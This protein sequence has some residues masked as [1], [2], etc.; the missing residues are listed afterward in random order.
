MIQFKARPWRVDQSSQ[1]FASWTLDDKAFF[2][3]ASRVIALICSTSFYDWSRKLALLS[4]PIRCK[5]QT[6][7]DLVVRVFPP[8]RQFW[9][10]IGC[11]SIFLSS[12][13]P[14][15]LLWVWF[16]DNQSKSA[17]RLLLLVTSIV[18]LLVYFFP[19][20]SDSIESLDESALTLTPKGPVGN[21]KRQ[22]NLSYPEAASAPSSKVTTPRRRCGAL[23]KTGSAC[24][25]V[26]VNGGFKCTTHLRMDSSYIPDEC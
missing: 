21:T 22:L 15:W 20:I 2:N 16:Y 5:T 18:N 9:V 4:Q 11:Q 10:L 19:P 12:D 13:W 17:L 14:L 1:S 26:I 8:F 7:D 23:T 6:N 3:W 25:R 24:K